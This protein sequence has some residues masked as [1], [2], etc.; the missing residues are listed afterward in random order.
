[1]SNVKHLAAEFGWKTPLDLLWL[2]GKVPEVHLHMLAST[3]LFSA[4]LSCSKKKD[5]VGGY[6]TDIA[7]WRIGIILS[8]PTLTSTS[9]QNGWKWIPKI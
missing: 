6:E 8:R 3:K 1:M 2:C 7:D 4:W 5:V 9:G